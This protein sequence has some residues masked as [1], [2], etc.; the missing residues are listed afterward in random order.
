MRKFIRNVLL[1]GLLTVSIVIPGFSQEEQMTDT[2]SVEMAKVRT[3][4]QKQALNLSDQ[5]KDLMYDINLKY[6]KEMQ[7]IRTEG[8][9][10]STLKKLMA[11]SDRMDK[12]VVTLLDEDQYKGYLKMKDERRKEMMKRMRSQ[13]GD[14]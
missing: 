11:M 10:V 2:V 5:Q 14:S 6:I 12:E 1:T 8:R 4:E 9:S 7:Q 13:R 3:E